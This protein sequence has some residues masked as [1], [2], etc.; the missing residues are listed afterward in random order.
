MGAIGGWEMLVRHPDLFA[1]AMLVCGEPKPEW[2]PE[3]LGAPIWAFH[4]ALDDVVTPGPA[5]AL[6]GEL[7]RQ[8]SP[9][10][11][12]EYADLAHISWNRAFNEAAVYD[13]LFAQVKR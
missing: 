9:V 5:R 4:G 12:T 13:W 10:R 8:G 3:L 6:C 7:A 1:A 2:A 11:F